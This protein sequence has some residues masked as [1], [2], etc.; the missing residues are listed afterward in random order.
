M[1]CV[2]ARVPFALAVAPT[3]PRGRATVT[4][5]RS[6]RLACAAERA[7]EDSNGNGICDILEATGCTDEAACNYDASAFTDGGFVL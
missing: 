3:S 4:A 2:A 5:T 6:T 1:V 7:Q